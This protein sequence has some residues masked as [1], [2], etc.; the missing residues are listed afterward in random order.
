MCI[1]NVWPPGG[2][3]S[4]EMIQ[5]AQQLR[6]HLERVAKINPRLDSINHIKTVYIQ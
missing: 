4:F 6:G 3:R 2:W 1:M 5:G